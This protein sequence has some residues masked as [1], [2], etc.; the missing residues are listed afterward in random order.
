MQRL[1]E[2]TEDSFNEGV[3]GSAVVTVLVVTGIVAVILV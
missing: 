1:I 2:M 3:L